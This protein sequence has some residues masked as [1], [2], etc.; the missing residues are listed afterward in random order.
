MCCKGFALKTHFDAFT[1]F[2]RLKALHRLAQGNALRP[3]D[4]FITS[5]NGAES[6]TARPSLVRASPRYRGGATKKKKIACAKELL[7]MT[8]AFET[9]VFTIGEESLEH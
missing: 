8:R 2:L 3:C 6:S 9:R 7:V 5:P 4:R 1:V